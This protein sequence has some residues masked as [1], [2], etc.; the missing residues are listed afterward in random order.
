MN[1]HLKFPK[2]FLI[3]LAE[4][5]ADPRLL[6]QV[7]Q[8]DADVP[9]RARGRQGQPAAGARPGH[10]AQGHVHRLPPPQAL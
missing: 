6:P 4:L 10:A 7:L 2:C 1:F 3:L 8:A 9:A 5:P